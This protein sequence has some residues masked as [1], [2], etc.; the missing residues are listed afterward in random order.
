MT[1]LRLDASVRRSRDGRVLSGSHP[2][3]VVR[4]SARGA[5]V[6]NAALKG[7]GH[8]AQGLIE[9]LTNHGLV[10]PVGDPEV[11]TSGRITF[12]IPV[13]DCGPS[14]AGLVSDLLGLGPVLVV[15][16]RSTDDTA[17]AARDAGARVVPN[18]LPP[19]PAGARTTGLRHVTTDLVG[20][21]DC[22]CL[23]SPG[24]L[25]PL[26]SLLRDPRLSLV[27]PRVVSA[28]GAS[29]L[30]RYE[31]SCSP[32]DLGS[33]PSLVSPGRRLLYVPSAALVGR[34]EA[35]LAVGGFDP[36]LRYGEDV[37]LVHRL[38]ASGSTVRY[39]PESTVSHRPRSNLGAFL[40]Q[41]YAYGTSAAVLERRYPGTAVPLRV[42]VGT[43]AVW[44]ASV[45][46]LTPLALA[47]AATTLPAASVAE[48]PIAKAH[49]M[50]LA[51]R[52]H[53]TATRVL[54]RA[55][56]REWLPVALLLSLRSRVARRATVAAVGTDFAAAWF[57]GDHPS[58]IAFPLLRTL[59]H[60][61]YSMGVWRGAA[62]ARSAAAL[63]PRLSRER[64]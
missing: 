29:A 6:L 18:A 60:V 21:V 62:R 4:L 2:P 50:R 57:H 51:A 36:M 34:T 32:L 43:G 63:L 42:S 9:K 19:G 53:V 37:D 44:A 25:A 40:R 47:S 20:F 24:W 45:A 31:R 59:D 27:A 52:G 23:P 1:R 49:A 48:H 46:G 8:D 38:L 35:L 64:G 56:T 30:A 14:I 28:P 16:D 55:I 54:A 10:H 3:R 58:T 11:P 22:D 33:E 41:R 12:V 39:A 17:A 7:T 26:V 61:S 5:E 13:K 15:D